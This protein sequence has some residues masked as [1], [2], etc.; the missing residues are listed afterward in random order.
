MID[1]EI[2]FIVDLI[3]LPF[4]LYR[5]KKVSTFSIQDKLKA[6]IMLLLLCPLLNAYPIIYHIRTANNFFKSIYHRDA[7]VRQTGI[8]NYQIV[9][10]YY[11][12]LT[13][14]QKMR[15][16]PSEIEFVSDWKKQERRETENNLTGIA[17]GKNL[18]IIQVESL[19]NF[20]IGMSHHGR[21][22]TPNLNRLVKEGIYFNNIYDQAA[23][24][25]SSDAT[26]LANCS[27]YPSRKGAVS[28]MYPQNYF[29]CMPKALEEHGYALAAMH[30]YKKSFWNSDTFERS[31]GFQYQFYEDTYDITDRIGGFLVGLSDRSFFL[32]SVEK[33]EKIPAPFYVF[34]RTLSSHAPFAQITSD[35]VD[36]P[37]DDLEAEGI[38]YYIRSM[39]Y[40]DSTIG[41]FLQKLSESN[42]RSN[43][44]V[45]VYGDHRTRLPFSKMKRIGVKDINEER[46]IP[47]IIHIPNEKL[48]IE[49]STIGGLIDV[50]PTICNILGVDISHAFFLG[51][52][53]LNSHE[54]FVIFRN[55]SYIC[56]C[57]SVN[58]TWA[59]LQ[60]M[61]SD[62]ILEKDML[63]V[64]RNEVQN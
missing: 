23:A 58:K 50:A 32:Q 25:N 7:F 14:K 27:L 2:L 24:G 28:Y 47:L 57:C 40:V 26:F 36:F 41:E 38:G 1:K 43:T 37:L 20:V 60:L 51:R 61:I 63:P 35:H 31:I 16:S 44:I 48:D 55:G 42:V 33:I 22:I 13:Q 62:L 5:F 15:I 11:V 39:H 34:M 53:L 10:L 3:V 64:L 59:E 49:S 19:Q 29:D 21:E 12:L 45:V 52:D 46:K 30:A 9:D 54:S 17:K 6:V 18:I 56:D 8:L 4:I